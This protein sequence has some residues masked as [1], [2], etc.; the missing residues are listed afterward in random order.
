MADES[1]RIDPVTWGIDDVGVRA[2]IVI[3]TSVY[4][5]I[6]ILKTTY[7]FT[8]RCYIFLSRPEG[9]PD[10]IEVEMRTKNQLSQDELVLLCREFYNSLIDQQVRQDVIAETGSIRDTLVKKAFFEGRGHLNPDELRS[11]G[12]N[13]PDQPQ[14]YKTDPLK[15]KRDAGS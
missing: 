11:D 6:A 14:G 1:G 15:I 5:K 2:L 3:D 4:S 8:E 7:W 9:R 10:T 13:V 12:T